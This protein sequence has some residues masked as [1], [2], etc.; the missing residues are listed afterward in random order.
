MSPQKQ[1]FHG[2]LALL[3]LTTV[4]LAGCQPAPVPQS[5]AAPSPAPEPAWPGPYFDQASADGKD[6]FRLVPATSRVDVLVRREGPLAR[7]GHDH[8]ITVRELEGFLLIGQRGE[9]SL[10]RLRFPV[11]RLEVDALEARRRYQLDTEP[12]EAD[13]NATRE[14]MLRG[15]LESGRWPYIFIE[16]SELAGQ[17]GRL[18]AALEVRVQDTVYSSRETF[19][20]SRQGE[21]IV[22][23][24]TLLLRQTE[25]G[26]EPFTALGGG[27]RVADTLEILLSLRAAPY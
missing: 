18:R 3:L 25:L 17:Q 26:L 15:V 5:A 21:E 13:I 22:V 20:L 10:A 2:S 24:G 9:D 16:M 23:E 4:M 12:D 14:N 19:E 7:F 11:E 8:V 6:V 27:L 1:T